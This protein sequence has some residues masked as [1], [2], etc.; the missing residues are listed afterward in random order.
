MKTRSFIHSD[1]QN[2]KHKKPER[3]ADPPLLPL[4]EWRQNVPNWA[5]KLESLTVKTL[6]FDWPAENVF[7]TRVDR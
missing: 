7:V 3:V 5:G 4:L 6:N 2:S 1:F